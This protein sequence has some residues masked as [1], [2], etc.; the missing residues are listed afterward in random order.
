MFHFSLF[1]STMD[2]GGILIHQL[3]DLFSLFN[4]IDTLLCI[5]LFIF[6]FLFFLYVECLW[7]WRYW[8][9]HEISKEAHGIA[10]IIV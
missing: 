9:P 1:V 8:A 10:T 5:F 3:Y 4:C 2:W 6:Y 7:V